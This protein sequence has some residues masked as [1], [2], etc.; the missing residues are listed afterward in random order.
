MVG[1]TEKTFMANQGRAWIATVGIASVVALKPLVAGLEVVEHFWMSGWDY[2]EETSALIFGAVYGSTAIA[3]MVAYLVAI[4]GF[5]LWLHR[6][7]ANAEALGRGVRNVSPGMAVLYW[8]IPILNLFRPYHVVTAL[9]RRSNPG[10]TLAKD[11]VAR[12]DWIPSA[13]WGTW[14]FGSMAENISARMAWSDNPE[15]HVTSMWA[16]LLSAPFVVAAGILVLLVLWSID[17]RLDH[18]ARAGAPELP[19]DDEAEPHFIA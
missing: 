4:V 7:V 2:S 13:W 16:D 8:F 6:T 1:R 9:Y 11:W 15:K 19:V 10:T 12:R 17:A 14:V 3:L 18:L 5:L